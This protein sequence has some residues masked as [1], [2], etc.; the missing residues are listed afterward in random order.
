MPAV[1]A[2]CAIEA[3][4]PRPRPR[5]CPPARSRTARGAV[6]DGEDVASA[7]VVHSALDAD[8]SGPVPSGRGRRHRSPGRRRRIDATI[9]APSPSRPRRRSTPHRPRRAAP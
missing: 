9:D 5:P 3:V 8:G 2:G 4:R 6:D 7:E 1:E